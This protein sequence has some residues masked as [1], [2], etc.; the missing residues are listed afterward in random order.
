MELECS[1]NMLFGMISGIEQAELKTHLSP[2]TRKP[3]IPVARPKL[4]VA[5]LY[6]TSV[7]QLALTSGTTTVAPLLLLYLF[8]QRSIHN[9]FLCARHKG[10]TFCP[11]GLLS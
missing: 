3:C 1:R 2:Y 5:D 11:Q 8:I 10:S 4:E 9:C 6:L 7:P